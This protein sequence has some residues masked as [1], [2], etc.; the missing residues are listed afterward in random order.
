MLHAP[1]HLSLVEWAL[2]VIG[3]GG[4]IHRYESKINTSKTAFVARAIY[5]EPLHRVPA[6]LRATP[7]QN[8]FGEWTGL[9][10]ANFKGCVLGTHRYATRFG[11]RA[12]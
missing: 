7:K 11:D 10:T 1:C 5:F 6:E 2:F 9:V 12:K 3:R 8:P 4:E